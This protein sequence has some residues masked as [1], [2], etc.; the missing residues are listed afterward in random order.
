MSY[1]VEK[2]EKNMAKITIEVPAEEFDTKQEA[3]KREYYI[4][5]SMTKQQKE[6]LIKKTSQV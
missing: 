2:L 6:N 4:K 5:H 1:T 3:M